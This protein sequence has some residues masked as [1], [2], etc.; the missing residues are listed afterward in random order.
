MLFICPPRDGDV[1][2]AQGVRRH[3]PKAYS[4]KN[5]VGPY[6]KTMDEQAL[7]ATYTP[8]GSQ[9]EAQFYHVFE[10]LSTTRPNE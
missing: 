3:P 10:S 2:K 4:L 8:A 6:S 9:D 5:S 1:M 7:R